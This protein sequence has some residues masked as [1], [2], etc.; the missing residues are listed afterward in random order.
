MSTV[1]KSLRRLSVL[2]FMPFNL[3]YAQMD[4]TPNR[5]LKALPAVD[6]IYQT[7][8]SR[9]HSPGLAYAIVYQGNVMHAGTLGHT[10]IERKMPVTPKS[11][12]RIASMTKSFVAAA[13]LQLRDS[14]L[15][16][17]DD[18]V[19]H[20]LPELNNQRLLTT[21]APQLTIRHLLTH[22]GGF[23]EDNPWGDRQLDIDDEAFRT[24]IQDGFTFSN[25]PGI[26]YEYSNTGFALLGEV[27][28]RV[29]GQRYDAYINTNLLKPLGMNETYWEY[30]DVPDSL[31]AKG[32]RWVNGQWVAQPMLHDG[33]YGAMGGLMT[34][35]ED[36]AKYASFFLQAWPARD[37]GDHGPL[38]RSSLREMQQPWTFNNLTAG[39]GCPV[40]SAYG[41]GLRWSH[42]CDGVTTVG[43]SGGLPGFGSNWIVLPDYGLGIICFSNVTYAPA[44]SVNLQAAKYIIS[45]SDLTPRP[46]AVSVVL[47]QRQQELM[48][49]LPDWEGAE[50][51]DSFA[52][53]FFLDNYID[54]LRS[55]SKAL[56]DKA[57]KVRKVNEIVAENNL[58]GTFVIECEHHDIAVYFTLSPEQTP[59]IQQY[60]IRLLAGER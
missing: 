46:K 5:I 27:I 50:G 44:T 16:K 3:T 7:F 40:T 9:Y 34:S 1:I 31:L 21:D 17:L 54:M 38:K 39:D 12:F 26:A 24:L 23:P 22:S 42:D 18:P 35:L 45:Q 8:A 13:I 56:F 10:D 52:V 58:R 59:R 6:S 32:Y 53:N 49:F 20:Y 41:Y 48:G 57:G 4:T 2:F 28:K 29:S 33:A 47:K 55:E 36:F 43:H 15:L 51:S 14:G 25:A 11:V 37:E 19:A 60:S 30:S